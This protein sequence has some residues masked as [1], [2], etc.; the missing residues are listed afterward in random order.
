MLSFILSFINRAF[1]FR[2]H[3]V[4]SYQRL[5]YCFRW[6][7]ITNALDVML[8]R[9]GWSMKNSLVVLLVQLSVCKFDMHEVT[10]ALLLIAQCDFDVIVVVVAVVVVVVVVSV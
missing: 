10:V 7:A 8:A 5:K 9:L 6:P 3:E 4:T 2:P 1:V